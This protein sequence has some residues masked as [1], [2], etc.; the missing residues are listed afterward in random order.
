MFFLVDSKIFN[1]HFLILPIKK[2]DLSVQITKDFERNAKYADFTFSLRNAGTYN[3]SY[4]IYVHEKR[5][6]T[7][8]N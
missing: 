4:S 3:V 5:L 2:E 7:A 1:L 8:N 6:Y